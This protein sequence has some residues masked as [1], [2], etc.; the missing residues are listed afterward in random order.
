[1]KSQVSSCHDI[2]RVI[3]SKEIFKLAFD[4]KISLLGREIFSN[5]T[6]FITNS[7]NTTS[8]NMAVNNYDL[9]KIKKGKFFGAQVFQKFGN[10][11]SRAA[12][13]AAAIANADGLFNLKINI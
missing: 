2:N 4:K 1:M 12:H 6:K 3:R 5:K 7:T 9:V 10:Y 8:K 13:T 11:L